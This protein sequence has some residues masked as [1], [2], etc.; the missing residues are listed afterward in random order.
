MDKST[1]ET[2]ALECGVLSVKP[3]KE[4]CTLGGIAKSFF[5][6]FSGSAKKQE[7]FGRQSVLTS[8]DCFGHEA[9]AQKTSQYRGPPPPQRR[10]HRV[11]SLTTGKRRHPKSTWLMT[12]KGP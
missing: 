9:L 3:N 4:I 7:K 1:I 8:G 12:Q 6:L 5:I 10:M 2:I 11:F